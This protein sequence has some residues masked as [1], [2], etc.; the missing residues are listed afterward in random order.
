MQNV[1]SCIYDQH[2]CSLVN[3]NGLIFEADS[4]F[5]SDDIP[6]FHLF[7]QWKDMNGVH[8]TLHCEPDVTIESQHISNILKSC[9]T[10]KGLNF[11]L[12]LSI[13]KEK[14]KTKIF[15]KAVAKAHKFWFKI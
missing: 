7:C 4:N 15:Q 5:V 10:A 3:N 6:L 11:N 2:V 13:F 9:N 1:F 8:A 12:L 14:L